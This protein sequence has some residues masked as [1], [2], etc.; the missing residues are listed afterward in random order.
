M[1]QQISLI[2]SIVLII[3]ISIYSFADVSVGLDSNYDPIFHYDFETG[4]VNLVTNQDEISIIDHSD[5]ALIEDGQLKLINSRDNDPRHYVSRTINT[6]NVSKLLI[7]KKCYIIQKGDYSLS[8]TSIENEYEEKLWISY[9]YYHYSAEP[10]V[11]QN[12]NHFYILNAF[13]NFSKNDPDTY[14]VSNLLDTS[15]SKWINEVIEIDY[16]NKIVKYEFTVDN[17]DIKQ[18]ALLNN[19]QLRKSDNTIIGLSAWDWAAGSSHFI[20]SIKVSAIYGIKDNNVT[21]KLITSAEILG[22]TACVGGATVKS[23]SN[24]VTSVTDIYGNFN[25]SNMPT[26]ENIIEPKSNDFVFRY[27]NRIFRRKYSFVFELFLN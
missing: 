17:S 23:S 27:Q 18:T 7:E 14:I 10:H 15:F 16:M 24:S 25:L 4:F 11:Y 5:T 19:I 8:S 20:D 9:N 3:N 1:R 22:Y 26:G 21:G 12:R 2:I 13:S 6:L